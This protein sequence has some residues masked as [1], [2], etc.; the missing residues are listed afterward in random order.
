MSASNISI[1]PSISKESNSSAKRTTL[2]SVILTKW[3]TEWNN[4][5]DEKLYYG[6]YAHIRKAMDYSY[7]SN[8]NRTRQWLQDSIIEKIMEELVFPKSC[9][10]YDVMTSTTDTPPILINGNGIDILTIPKEPWFVMVAGEEKVDKG[11]ALKNL[12]E[13]D[14]FPLM[15][16]V[17]V[18]P[19]E[20][21]MLLLEYGRLE[22]KDPERIKEVTR[23]EAG[24]IIE[25]LTLAAI[26]TGIN[27]VVYGNFWDVLWYQKYC[28]KLK[29]DFKCLRIAILHIAIDSKGEEGTESLNR[30]VPHI[31]FLCALKILTERK[32]C[33]EVVTKGVTWNLFTER[34]KQSRAWMPSKSRSRRRRSC[35]HILVT[36]APRS[37]IINRKISSS[38]KNIVSKESRHHNE[39]CSI[40]RFSIEKSTE[41]NHKS[42]NMHFYG[43]YAH[44]RK[45]LDYSYHSNYTRERQLL[46]DAIISHFMRK[47]KIVD[48]EGQVGTTP[49]LPFIVFTAGA[50]G[51]GKSHV[52]QYLHK[53]RYFP[54]SSFVIADPDE[55]RNHF[56]EYNVYKSESPLKAGELTKKEAGYIVEIL[57][58][59]AIQA[60]KNILIDGSLR[61]SEWYSDYFARLK[62]EFSCAKIC[63]LHI[64][65]PNDEVIKRAKVSV[66]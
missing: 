18:D 19:Q 42:T 41:K 21:R 45:T 48:D 57:S 15:Y 26:E 53:H 3:S 24:Y 16:F 64:V 1:P 56:P 40:L 17:L 7:H 30:L 46:Q 13:H 44:I 32:N 43:P 12:M 14:R 63:I 54:L 66:V 39:K 62:N 55:I 20:I 34:W 9:N 58:C 52:I 60:G 59:A 31:D 23:V 29:R 25:I 36:L 6:P 50:M 22:Q 51:V 8:Y 37:R 10:G 11:A 27:V 38:Q 2:E 35:S 47:P 28:R 65:A 33:I 5:T 61:H 4:R 49:T